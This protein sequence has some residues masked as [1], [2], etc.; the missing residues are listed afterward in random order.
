MKKFENSL[1]VREESFECGLFPKV[2]KFNKDNSVLILTGGI[3]DDIIVRGNT[4]TKDLR[5][6]K[7]TKL[8]EVSTDSYIKEIKFCSMSKEMAYSFDVYV[9]AV[10]QV[11][12]PLRFY[13][14]RNID[15][16]AYFNNLF[17]MDVKKITKK[18]SIL[19]FE[20]MDEEL[21]RRLA[22][23]NT[24]DEA[25]G[26]GYQISAVHATPGE[27]ATDYVEKYGQQL[28]NKTLKENAHKLSEGYNT[29]YEEAIKS[30]VISGEMTELEAIEK[31]EKHSY[32]VIEKTMMMCESMKE[33]GAL[34]DTDVAQIGRKF[35]SRIENNLIDKKKEKDSNKNNFDKYY[36]EEDD[37]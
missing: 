7:Y 19:D 5:N 20:G 23:Y 6:G 29:N 34:T 36:D 27:K 22:A 32:D 35:I 21:I 28:L 2:P 17:S 11:K 10:I 37:V 31:I 18:Y 30:A 24:T 14:N 26:L 8:V 33:R 12:D 15:V 25:T 9:K 16:D 13:H 3:I 4:T 1:I